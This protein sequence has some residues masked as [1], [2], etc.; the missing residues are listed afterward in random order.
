MKHNHRAMSHNSELSAPRAR[1]PSDYACILDS[2]IRESVAVLALDTDVS[3]ALAGLVD[4]A[5]SFFALPLASKQCSTLPPNCGYRPLGVEY[6]ESS[7][8]P[9]TIESFT[10]SDRAANKAGTLQVPEARLLHGAAYSLLQQLEPVAEDLIMLLAARVGNDECARRLKGSTRRWS[11][12]Q[13]NCARPHESNDAFVHREHE[14]G[15]VLTFVFSNSPGLEIRNRD[16][17]YRALP[18]G[19]NEMVLMVGSVTQLLTGGL[20]RPL[21][22]RVRKGVEGRIAALYFVDIDPRLCTPWAVNSINR[23]VDIGERVLANSSRFGL[24]GFSIE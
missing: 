12:L 15:H 1:M 7:S 3:R 5:R 9:D 14:D 20:V 22:H 11:S 17:G 2:L 16:G 23:G 21:F 10:A 6:S 19:T 18:T 8:H 24:P 4:A 13:I